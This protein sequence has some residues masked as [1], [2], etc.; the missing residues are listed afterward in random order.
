MEIYVKLF[1]S[2]LLKATNA[3]CIFEYNTLNI[4]HGSRT[5]GLQQNL[6]CTIFS[7]FSLWHGP[8]EVISLVEFSVKLGTTVEKSVSQPF[9]KK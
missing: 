8:M 9:F 7:T 5:I 4:V 3:P 2:P 6:C 1:Q